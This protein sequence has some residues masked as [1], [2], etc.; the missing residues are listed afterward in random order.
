VSPFQF[1]VAMLCGWLRHEQDNI[2]AFLH[3]ENRILKARLEGRRLRLHDCERRRLAELGHRLGRRALA[4]VATLVT[5]DTILRWHRELVARKWTYGRAHGSRAGLQAHLRTLVIR[6]ATDNP[7][8][9]YTRIQG[10][11]K[12]LGHRVGR[13][14]VA[15]ILHAYG[16]PPGRQRSTTWRTFIQA[17]WSALVAADFFSTEVWTT[18]GLVTYYTAFVIELQ[19]RRVTVIG[20]TPYPD[21]AFVI[22]CLRQ[23]A[24]EP[25]G[26]L[27]EGQIVI[28]DRDVKW[29][30][31]LEQFLHGPHA[32]ECAELQRPR[33]AIRPDDKRGVPESDRPNR[34]T[35]PEG[36][37]PGVRAALSSRAE[38]S[39]ARKRIDRTSRGPTNDRRRSSPPACRRDSQLLL[40]VCCVSGINRFKCGTER[41][42]LHVRRDASRYVI[43][44][45][46]G[47]SVSAPVALPVSPLVARSPL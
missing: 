35:A 25:D 21:E 40:S 8:W 4:Q 19:T 26:L 41:A 20:S 36:D 31:G 44:D 28:C 29:S 22:Q 46:S 3:E 13:S 15:R 42:L 9:G 43:E 45:A 33:G 11:L 38:S 2:V 30:R 47:R 14:T 1:L 16:I 32:A 12:N 27:R 34:G 6:M 23:V 10:A 5:P 39:R 18:R 37:A 24:S 7:T 17:H